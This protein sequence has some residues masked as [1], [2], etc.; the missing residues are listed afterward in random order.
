VMRSHRAGQPKIR[1]SDSRRQRHVS[2]PVFVCVCL[3]STHRLAGT[4]MLAY[5]LHSDSVVSKYMLTP[6]SPKGSLR[7][8]RS[9][10]LAQFILFS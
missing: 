4:A 3:V 6:R 10:L 1:Q 2:V 9:V 5:Q 8:L 7:W